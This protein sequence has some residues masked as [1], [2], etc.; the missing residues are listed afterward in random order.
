MRQ[1][2]LFSCFLIAFTVPYLNPI[3][4]KSPVA[5]A[6]LRYQSSP[7]SPLTTLVSTN[8]AVVPI[9]L[10]PPVT[11]INGIPVSLVLVTLLL[12]GIVAVSVLV[13]WRQR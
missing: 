7:L 12:V 4:A 8:T 5:H 2:F 6:A 1:L 13:F 10:P 9:S 11:P 3:F